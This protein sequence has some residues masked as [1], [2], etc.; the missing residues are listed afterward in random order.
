VS[1]TRAP[2]SGA[3]IFFSLCKIFMAFIVLVFRKLHTIKCVLRVHIRP[4]ALRELILNSYIFVGDVFS[5]CLVE[6]VL[7]KN[8]VVGCQYSVVF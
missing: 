8:D 7:R 3:L 6:R 1:E 5:Q 2:R 4:H